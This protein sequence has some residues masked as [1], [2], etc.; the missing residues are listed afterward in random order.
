MYSKVRKVQDYLK[1]FDFCMNIRNMT[2]KSSDFAE[3]AI[4]LTSELSH[5]MLVVSAAAI[6][7][8]SACS[9]TPELPPLQADAV[10]LAFGDSLTFGTGAGEAESYPAVLASLTG[11][12]VINAGVPGEVSANGALR[13][14][15]LLE[16]ERPGLLILCHGGNDLLQRQDQRQLADNLRTMIRVA[17]ERGVSVVLVAVPSLGLTLKPPQ[18][19]RELAAEFYLPIEV[20][21]LPRIL[22]KSALKS[23]QIHPNAAGYR[24]LAEALAG[25]LKTSGALPR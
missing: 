14:P 12:R 21:A 5:W 2:M 17:R 18:L 9:K 23:D 8:L 15:E 20:K 24:T 25:L 7:L 1:R 13:L 19:Y 16:R 6:L 10:I 4:S 3:N 11:R 22:G